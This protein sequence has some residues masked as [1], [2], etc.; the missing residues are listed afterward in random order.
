MLKGLPFCL[1]T[2][3]KESP[4]QE[5]RFVVGRSPHSFDLSSSCFQQDI[6]IYKKMLYFCTRVS[7]QECV[8]TCRQA[9]QAASVYQAGHHRLTGGGSFFTWNTGRSKVFVVEGQGVAPGHLLVS[10][11]F[12]PFCRPAQSPLCLISRSPGSTQDLPGAPPL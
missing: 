10:T 8:C 11:T 3:P 2:P 4:R 5:L 1:W 6:A 12:S 9:A 7:I